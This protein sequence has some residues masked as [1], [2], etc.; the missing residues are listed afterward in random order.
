MPEC[1]L[2]T[3]LHFKSLF[4]LLVPAL[5]TGC[6]TER[7]I[8]K[9]GSD[10]YPLIYQDDST[11][12]FSDSKDAVFVEVRRRKV[13]RPLENLAIHYAALFPGGE[14]VKPGDTEEYVK[15]DGRNAYKVVFRTNY[16]RRR[17]RIDPKKKF[18]PDKVPPGWTLTNIEDPI[19][20]KPT[21]VLYG[22]V[23]PRQKIL[24][25]VEGDPYVYY[26]FFRADGDAIEPARKKFEEFVRKGIKYD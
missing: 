13:S 26:I 25:L 18:D 23:I 8:V 19:T 11:E 6:F 22:P 2:S 12:K 20:G 3:R 9:A 5:L 10:P 21:P 14:V 24:Y 15:I 16:I 1:S 7:S 17:K 4:W